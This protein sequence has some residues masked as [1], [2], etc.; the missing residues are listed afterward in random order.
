MTHYHL[1]LYQ[2]LA[3]EEENGAASLSHAA[4]LPIDLCFPYGDE[5]VKVLRFAVERKPDDATAW[6][7]LGNTLADTQQ[8]AAVECWEKAAEYKS[9]EAIIYRNM[10]Y[11]QANH[12]GRMPEALKNIMKAISLDP[13]Q[14][15]YFSEAQL[16]MSYASL[17]PEQLSTFLAEYGELGKDVVD[18]QLMRIKLNIYNGDCDTAINLLEQ[19][20][21]HIK[22]GATFNPHVYWVDAHLQKGRALMDRSEY[23]GAEQAFLRAMEFPANLEAERN[24]KTGIVQYYLGLNSKLAGDGD[25]ARAHFQAMVDYTPASGWGAGNFPEL[26][27]FKALAALELGGD[28]QAAEEQFRALI[29]KGENRPGT[30]KDGRHITVSVAESHSARRFLLEHEL[31]RKDRRVSSYYIQ[32]LGYLGLGDWDQARACFTKALEIDP[33]SIDAKYMLES[34]S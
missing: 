9:G 19:L 7:L 3:G 13:S 24:S 20:Q 4:S 1:G 16:Y 26:E 2:C 17:T 25:T 31:G 23:A 11:L 33:M 29:K 15:R 21:Y 32:G 27:Y 34:L 6:Y 30:V 8:E 22:E 14:A 18:I 12:L 28:K 5:S 10:A